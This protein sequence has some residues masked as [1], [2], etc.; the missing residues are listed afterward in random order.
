MSVVRGLGLSV[1]WGALFSTSLA[2]AQIEQ[3]PEW[4]EMEEQERQ[5]AEEE[6][7]GPPKLTK[8]PKLV[9][10][11]PVIYPESARVEK[12]QGTA[13]LRITIDEEGY[14]QRLDVLQ[15]AGADLDYAAMGAVANFVFEPAEVDG[16]PAPIQVD[17]KQAFV[18]KE[19][20]REVLIRP[21]PVP[22]VTGAPPAP[23]PTVTQL[24]T[25]EEEPKL[26]NF[27]GVVR[28]SGTKAPLADAEVYVQVGSPEEDTGEYTTTT[29]KDGRFELYGVP[30]GKHLVRLSATG[31]E[32]M[33]TVEEFSEDEAVQ[34]I[35]YLP[36]RSYN[37]FE[38]VIQSKREKKEVSRIALRREE[39]SQVPGTFGDPIRVIENLPG[40]ARAPLLG[41]ALLVRGANPEDTGVYMDGVPIPLLYHFLALT[42]VVNAEFLET[43]DFYPGGFGARFGRATAGIVD[44]RTRDLRLR[45][46]RG[47]AKIDLID[48]GFFFGCPVT[49]WGEE[50]DSDAPSWRRITFAAAARRSYLDSLLPLFMQ[51]FLPPGTGTLFA[52]PVYWDYQ[53]K[54]EYRPLAGHT[55]TLFAFGSDDA[56]KVIAGG[57]VDADA[58]ELR[59]QQTF[60]RVL[61]AWEWRMFPRLTNRFAPWVGLEINKVGLGSGDALGVNFDLA[62][63]TMGLRDDLRYQVME[64]LSLNTG[65]DLQSGV[66]Q[67]NAELPAQ[68]EI[69]AFPRVLPRFSEN[70]SLEEEGVGTA[71]GAYVEAEIGPF[72]GVKVTPGF[73]FDAYELQRAMNYSAGPRLA[74]RWE[75]FPGTTLKGAYGVYE[76]MSDPQTRL[77]TLGNPKVWPER[78]RHH[79]LGIEQK[80]TSKINVDFQV[81]YNLKNNLVVSSQRILGVEGGNVQAEY[82]S[83]EGV[84]NAWGAEILL[85]H[86]L[87]KQFF[88]WVAYTLMRSEE[89]ERLGEQWMLSQFD[90][91]HI[92]TIVGQYKLP[93]HLP[94][95]EWS[96]TGRLPRG[97]WWNTG[98]AILSGDWSVGG[99]FRAVSGNPTTPYTSA[100]H[101]LDSSEFVAKTGSR[102]SARLPAFH[103]LDIRVDYKMA[104][105]NFIVACYLD[106]LNVYNQKNAETMVWD[107][108]YRESQ[109]LAL[110]PLLPVVGVN[111]EF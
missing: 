83:N 82:Y 5:R 99:R 110:L 91:T 53:A 43:I 45:R 59:T 13:V 102:R 28:E 35:Y 18:L 25:E 9:H 69:G 44:V 66:F 81:F 61:A 78:S 30:A 47:S 20:V 90:Q 89:R 15:S 77:G 108:R 56:L 103:Q 51:L 38:T 34:A 84:G 107:F 23:A 27:L 97:L 104:F 98:W 93:W 96:R 54:L 1:F 36:R 80:L 75:V 52:S 33:T 12:R 11:V 41:G 95:R 6:A 94:F 21:P 105:D 58:F 31:Y 73:R 92:L 57:N 50:V 71:L 22:D 3:Q 63:S 88:G 7:K 106:L 109:P 48:T 8:P 49:L 16:I 26:L 55:F 32:Q 65:L 111:A 72:A 42:S 70:Q 101:D 14:V 39:L 74:V 10:Q 85:R 40:M 68:A 24:P 60:H 87:S 29:G 46:C 4:R 2:S 67:F 64:G 100:A 79:I 86:E 19:E 76:K 62:I 17:Y 37:K